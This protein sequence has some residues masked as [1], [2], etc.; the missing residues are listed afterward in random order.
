[1]YEILVGRAPYKWETLEQEA[2][3]DGMPLVRFSGL[4]DADTLI[5][6]PQNVSDFMTAMFFA[7]ACAE[8]GR[9]LTNLILPAIPGARQ[10]RLNPEGDY[11]F[12]L[13]S[14]AKMINDR[15]FANVVTFDPHSNVGPALVNNCRVYSIKD[16]FSE[17]FVKGQRKVSVPYLGVIAPDAGA[18]KRAI[19]AAQALDVDFVQAKKYRYVE[20]G[21]L[22][23]FECDKLHRGQHY[24]V[25]DDICDGGGTFLGLAEIIR[26][27][28]ATADLYVS[29]GIFSKGTEELRKHYKNVYTTD[30]TTFPRPNVNVISI[31]ERLKKCTL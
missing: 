29:H 30:S 20:S 27:A 7:D 25:V 14:V 31:L 21:K 24:L 13:K 23:G 15:N 28:G 19:D 26:Q 22:A 16:F 18:G 10:D 4:D 3:P 12:T 5:V 2:Y 9:P 8:R 1:M 11:L 17:W 6:R